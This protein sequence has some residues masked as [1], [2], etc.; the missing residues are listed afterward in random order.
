ESLIRG[1]VTWVPA[2]HDSSGGWPRCVWL[3]SSSAECW[4][5]PIDARGALVFTDGGRVSWTIVT[6]GA[7]VIDFQRRAWGRLILIGDGAGYGKVG[8]AIAHP[9]TS[10]ARRTSLRL[11]TA[12]VPDAHAVLIAADAVWVHGEQIPASSWMELKAPR[13]GPTYLSLEDVA[14]APP[15]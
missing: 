7:P 5:S 4:G 11:E 9:V 6:P 10:A 2:G 15:S 8:A 1:D 13:A 12:L 14:R 3:G